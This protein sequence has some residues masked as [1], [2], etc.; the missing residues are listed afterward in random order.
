MRAMR[1]ARFVKIYQESPA[2]R[3]QLST[4]FANNDKLY[5][6]PWLKP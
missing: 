1:V 3:K 6:L 2:V 4:S 5:S